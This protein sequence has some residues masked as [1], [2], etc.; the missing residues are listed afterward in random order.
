MSTM[1]RWSPTRQFH[2]H[3]DADDMFERFFGAPRMR[4]LSVRRGFPPRRGGSKTAPT[5][6]SSPSRAS[7]RRRSTCP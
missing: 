7:I 4:P 5:S 2:F 3:H 6:S 1:L